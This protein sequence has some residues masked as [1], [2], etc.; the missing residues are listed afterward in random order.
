MRAQEA[1]RPASPRWGLHDL[2]EVAPLGA[3]DLV[4]IGA[5]RGDDRLVS[6]VALSAGPPVTIVEG[7][8][9]WGSAPDPG[10]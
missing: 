8:C 9:G 6:V 1:A 2:D 5:R 3:N 4:V 10:I 7:R